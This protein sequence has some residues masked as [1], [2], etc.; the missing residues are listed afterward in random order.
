MKKQTAKMLSILLIP[1]TTFLFNGCG[2]TEI[3]NNELALDEATADSWT[4]YNGKLSEYGH[5]NNAVD[6]NGDGLIDDYDPDCHVNP[7]PLRDLSLLPFPLGHNFAPAIEM[8]LPFG[9]GYLGGFRDPALITRWF[10]FLTEYDGWVNGIWLLGPGV[11]PE[12]VPVPA[13]L[14]FHVN[15]G[16]MHP[17]NNNN[18]PV[19]LINGGPVGVGGPGGPVGAAGEEAPLTTS[20]QYYDASYPKSLGPIGEFPGAFYR[21]QGPWSGRARESNQ[22]LMK[23]TPPAGR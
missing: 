21:A 22:P 9:P 10:R 17:G 2:P 8:D 7:G 12:V 11:N 4:V 13:P 14:P 3:A 18:L 1:V 20:S 16:T 6:D 5:C 15:L 23:A 19:G